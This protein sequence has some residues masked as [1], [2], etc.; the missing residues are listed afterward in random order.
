MI[1][2]RHRRSPRFAVAVLCVLATGA[3]LAQPRFVDD[4]HFAQFDAIT[5]RTLAVVHRDDGHWLSFGT[6]IDQLDNQEQA[7]LIARD[8]SGRRVQETLLT[9][10]G[11]LAFETRS[12]LKLDGGDVAVLLSEHDPD[13]FQSLR[14]AVVIRLNAALEP[15]WSQRI[16]S[17]G[18]GIEEPML[19]DGGNGRIALVGRLVTQVD[20]VRDRGDGL[21]VDLDAGTGQILGSTTLGISD[22]GERVVDVVLVGESGERL[23]LLALSHPVS[24]FEQVTSE[25]IAL[26]DAKG[27]VRA[28]QRIR[29]PVASVIR[30]QPLRLLPHP[31]GGWTLAGRRTAF[32]PNFYYLHRIDADLRP[33]AQRV[34][35]PLF[36]V[37]DQGFHDGSYWLYGEANTEFESSGSTLMRLDAS[38]NLSLQRHYGTQHAPFPSGG[39]A[40][41][42]D[43][44]LLGIG[45]QHEDDNGLLVYDSARTV[46]LSDGEGL[47]C[48]EAQDEGFQTQIDPGVTLEPWPALAAAV[49]LT[50][51]PLSVTGAT[52]TTQTLGNC[53]LDDDLIFADGFDHASR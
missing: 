42:G 12:L 11:E 49:T 14:Q 28:S 44:A 2:F 52:L 17:A 32:G 46:R 22:A 29:H 33:A 25:G 45:S 6:V 15:V 39:M 7:W 50:A 1:A 36:N 4:A 51:R 24:P 53:R 35:V 31:D 10:E 18:T 21:I 27:V 20:G 26:L 16:G 43:R 40:F 23:A 34:L 13:D 48:E 9:P 38:L 5:L 47:M 19:R 37:I 8:H 41:H 3:V 30:I